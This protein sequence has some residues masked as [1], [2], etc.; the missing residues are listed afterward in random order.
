MSFNVCKPWKQLF[1]FEGKEF[2]TKLVNLVPHDV[3]VMQEEG[4]VLIPKGEDVLRLEMKTYY[5]D[6]ITVDGSNISVPIGHTVFGKLKMESGKPV[7]RP[8]QD[9]KYI[10]SL[11][12][13]RVA[14]RQDFLVPNQT[15]R[16]NGKVVG[17]RSLAT[18]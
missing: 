4:N 8:R 6:R 7:P 18:I 11:E 10:V 1:V 9:T 17:C 3:V 15:I 12:V 14:G 2:E 5:H 16:E 13:A